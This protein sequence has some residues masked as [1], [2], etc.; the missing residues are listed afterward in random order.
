MNTFLNTEFRNDNIECAVEYAYH[1]SGTN[2]RAK[3][4]SQIVNEVAEMQVGG[5]LLGDFGGV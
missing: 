3:S 1:S 2:D 4:L 5:L